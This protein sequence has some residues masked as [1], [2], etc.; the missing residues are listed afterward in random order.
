MK[1]WE[2]EAAYGQMQ[3][4]YA[5]LELK[6]GELRVP[7]RVVSEKNT[8]LEEKVAVLEKRNAALAEQ[9][10]EVAALRTEVATLK[11]LVEELRRAGKRQAGPFRR[12][13]DKL[14]KDPKKPGRKPGQ[15]A[16]SSRAEPTAEQQAG[17][18]TAYSRLD[19][20]PDCGGE[21]TD[22]YPTTTW[23]VDVPPVEPVWTRFVG[24]SGY[25]AG[26]RRRVR[27]RHPEQVSTASGA[28]GVVIGPRAKALAADM[29]HTFGTSYAKVSAFFAV[30]FRLPATPSGL[31][32]ADM[33]LASRARPVYAELIELIRQAMQAFTDE[34]GWRGPRA[35]PWPRGVPWRIGTLSAWLWVFSSQDVTVYTIRTSRGHEVVLDILGRQFRGVL[36]CDGL[37]TY[38]AAALS[39]WLKQK[40][41]ARILRRLGELAESSKKA[42]QQLAAAASE[43][44][45]DALALARQRAEL[46]EP[47]YTEAVMAIELRL[48][49]VIAAYLSEADDDGAR[50][51]RHLA[52]HREN[53]LRFLHI[54]GLEATN[55]RAERDLRPGV[56]T[57][58]VGGCNRTKEGARAHAV[59]A[60]IG[61]TCRKRGIDVIDFL[62]R[63]QCSD[64]PPSIAAP[65]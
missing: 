29:K 58:K 32:Q 59:L 36:T 48:D 31:F 62:I 52:K 44:L 17:A 12:D 11:E 6:T 56:I 60:S 43:V 3:R 15:G 47:A 28:A 39:T 38:D 40:C 30:A 37:L 57:R 24:E 33:R 46:G 61:A 65:S 21:V 22:L 7:L 34:T 51:A 20:C 50:M 23:Q 41:L 45:R 42:H 2:L 49:A 10:A 8:T 63:L 4:E 26:C 35:A 14:T 9:A 54:E 1:R 19:C 13:A 27:T 53:L 25:C 18:T 5:A 64:S 55:N 16:W